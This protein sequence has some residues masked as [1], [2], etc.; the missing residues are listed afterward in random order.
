MFKNQISRA[1]VWAGLLP[2]AMGL[3][4]LTL[5]NAAPAIKFWDLSQAPDWARVVLFMTLVQVGF[6]AWMVILPDWSTVWVSMLVFA[7]VATLYG[8]ALAIAVVT[9]HGRPV[10]L[11]MDDIRQSARLWCAAVVLLT[12]SMTYLCGRL[13]HQWYKGYLLGR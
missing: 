13:S 9:P 6:V 7:A 5:F 3:L 2:L 8:V 10:F 12:C 11:E 1:A 4:L